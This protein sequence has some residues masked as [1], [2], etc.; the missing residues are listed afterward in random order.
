[1]G[2]KHIEIE[3]RQDDDGF[4]GWHLELDGV[5]FDSPYASLDTALEMARLEA[6]FL[7]A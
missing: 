5:D 3:Y 1:M 7:H 2:L 6:R 4:W